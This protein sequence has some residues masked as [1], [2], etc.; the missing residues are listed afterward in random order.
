MSVS[1]HPFASFDRIASDLCEAFFRIDRD[2][3]VLVRTD[4]D[5]DD[6]LAPSAPEANGGVTDIEIFY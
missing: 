1:F 5:D 3:A 6:V 2:R 4:D